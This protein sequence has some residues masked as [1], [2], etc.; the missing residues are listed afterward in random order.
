[1]NTTEKSIAK[2]RIAVLF[3]VMLLVLGMIFYQFTSSRTETQSPDDTHW[4][5]FVDK[6][7]GLSFS[8]PSAWGQATS[9]LHFNILEVSREIT[10]SQRPEV[11]M[12]VASPHFY[13]DQDIRENHIFGTLFTGNFHLKAF[14]DYQKSKGIEKRA[15]EKLTDGIDRFRCRGSYIYGECSDTGGLLYAAE[16]DTP[17]EESYF[18]N[19]GDSTTT[20]KII[21]LSKLAYKKL[22][23]PTYEAMTLAVTLPD[24]SSNGF[25]IHEVSI[26]PKRIVRADQCMNHAEKTRIEKTFDEFDQSRLGKEVDGVVRSIQVSVSSR[27]AYDQHFQEL[28][29][30]E[31]PEL[32]IRFDYPKNLGEPKRMLDNS[33][34]LDPIFVHVATK[35]EVAKEEKMAVKAREESMGDS[36]GYPLVS[37]KQWE[38]EKTAFSE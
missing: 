12:I 13:T 34:S 36:P 37:L 9:N 29:H 28:A 11:K 22:T 20:T 19:P 3:L 31:N 15:E 8:Y 30:Y 17:I 26:E 23:G 38:V 21:Q 32:G 18:K 2:P 7:T 16:K 5:S 10:F 27:E 6:E 35:D 4:A 33:V 14:C 25:C 24:L 1:M